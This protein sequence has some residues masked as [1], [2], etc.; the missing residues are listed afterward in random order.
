MN[1]DIQMGQPHGFLKVRVDY[2]GMIKSLMVVSQE[3]TDRCADAMRLTPANHLMDFR[4]VGIQVA[5]QCGKSYCMY[6]FNREN[7]GTTL[8]VLKDASHRKVYT[9]KK[10]A[11]HIPEESVIL[12]ETLRKA[13]REWNDAK[14]L[15]DKADV[16][17]KLRAK[18]GDHITHVILDDAAVMFSFLA[19]KRREF[20]ELIAS[21]WGVDLF[22][23]CLG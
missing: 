5:R 12:V 4:T 23:V 11:S 1:Q 2:V 13:I 21:T 16:S 6:D 22:I 3:A 7:P 20:Y 15:Q 10:A 14:T 8:N 9:D 19:I 18:Y 17:M